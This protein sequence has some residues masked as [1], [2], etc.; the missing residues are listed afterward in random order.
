VVPE[1]ERNLLLDADG[2]VVRQVEAGTIWL[3]V[4]YEIEHALRI[5]DMV[6]VTGPEGYRIELTVA[7]FVR[8][9]IM[10]TAVASAQ[11]LA[12]RP[13]PG[14]VPAHRLPGGGDAR[15]GP[16]GRPHRL[17]HVQPD[18]RRSGRRRR[19][20][21]GNRGAGGRDAVPAAG[22]GHRDGP[23][24]PRERGDARDRDAG[25]AHRPPPA[26]EEC[27]DRGPGEPA[28]SARRLGPGPG[29][30]GPPDPL[31]GR[32]RRGDDLDRTGPD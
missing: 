27:G 4:Y 20:A 30:D 1:R 11:R 10:N 12:V 31:S 5:G 23:R 26:A 25:I 9:A 15:G 18:Q 17:Q 28:R 7:G 19:A 21:G 6:T 29:P 3:P 24:E 13:Q 16:H 32:L 14:P 2:G 22:A 8:D